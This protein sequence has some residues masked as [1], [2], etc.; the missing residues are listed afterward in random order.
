MIVGFTTTCAT[1]AHHHWCCE[2]KHRSWRCVLD[3]A[4]YY[5]VCQWLATGRWFSPGTLVS[6]TNKPHH[7]DIIEIL[8]KVAL[9]TIKPNPF[10]NISI[11]H[12]IRD[13]PFNLQG[14]LWFFVSFRI[15]FSDITRVRIFF[16]S[17]TARN[18]FPEFNIDL[19]DKNSESDYFFF[20]QQNQNIF[21]ATL[22][23]TFFEK[24][25]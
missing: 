22:G 16:F 23:I 3:T 5:K 14:G 25:T 17:R 20:L 13:R 6:S 2:S 24:K 8:S 21:S 9:N 12:V 19:Y 1:S 11:W 18:I 10:M 4:L 7:H 15:F